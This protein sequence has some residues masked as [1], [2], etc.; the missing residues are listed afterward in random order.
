MRALFFSYSL[1]LRL[2]RWYYDFEHCVQREKKK[3]VV[4]EWRERRGGT[5]RRT[6]VKTESDGGDGA[7]WLPA[8]DWWLVAGGDWIDASGQP[9]T[10]LLLH[11]IL[12][13][14]LSLLYS[15]LNFLSII[16]KIEIILQTFCCWKGINVTMREQRNTWR[17]AGVLSYLSRSPGDIAWGGAR[18]ARHGQ[19]G[20]QG[21][22]QRQARR[23]VEAG[24]A[25]MHEL[26]LW[27]C[28]AIIN[29]LHTIFSKCHLLRI[30]SQLCYTKMI[31]Y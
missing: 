18:Q 11:A 29:T 31:T 23:G 25:G 13:R 1:P 22:G 16:F 20:R 28:S 26:Q 15:F 17:G 9:I 10:V 8:G 27:Q 3:S 21:A 24:K 2:I 6:K 4:I 14:L 12:H 30:S 19:G 5:R 7:V